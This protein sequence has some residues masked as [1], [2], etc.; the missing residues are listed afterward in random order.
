MSEDKIREAV[1]RAYCHPENSHKVL[2][3]VLCEAIVLELKEL[4]C[5]NK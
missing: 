1:G 2:D 4:I 3:P 5:S